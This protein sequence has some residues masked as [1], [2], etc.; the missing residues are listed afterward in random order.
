MQAFNIYVVNETF[1]EGAFRIL[2]GS[3][4]I[5]VLLLLIY[6]HFG[7]KKHDKKM[8]SENQ[9]GEEMIHLNS[10]KLDSSTVKDKMN[11]N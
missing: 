4:Y 6:T 9:L 11:E 10:E 2:T 1:F 8:E 3:L 7:L 5:L